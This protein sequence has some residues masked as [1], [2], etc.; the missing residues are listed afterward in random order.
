METPVYLFT[1]FLEAGKTRFIQGTL[2]DERF[3][4]D[5]NTLVLVCEEGEEELDPSSFTV[6]NVFVQTVDDASQL[7]RENLSAWQ[8]K[9]KT[10]RVLIEYNGMWPLQALFDAFPR[11]WIIAQELLFADARTFLNYNANMHSLVVDKLQTCDMVI[12]NR[13]HALI[14]K[15]EFH[16]IV[17]GISRGA[18]I[19]YEYPDGHAEYDE[20]EDPLPF[21]ID[22]P[23][24]EIADRDYA[25]WFRDFSEE[26]EKYEGKTVR[27]KGIVAVDK[28]FPPDTVVAGRHIMTCCVEDIAYRGVV[29]E[30]AAVGGF[31]KGDWAVITA[32]VTMQQH[33][34][35]QGPGPV[36]KVTAAEPAEAP[37]Q[38]VA[39]FY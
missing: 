39:T 25:L 24:I 38:E 26:P 31:K 11:G 34:L 22:A 6:R 7:T 10:E 2:E 14:D 32:T 37:E 17:R 27:F 12:F 36:L 5:E 18:A 8:K 16:K 9:H 23:V 1:G 21:D 35:Y 19:A 30:G 28:N 20:M 33:A 29:C 3:N 4:T 15:M 13:T